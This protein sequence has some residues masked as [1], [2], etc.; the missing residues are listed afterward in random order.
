VLSGSL[1][2]QGEC[3]YDDGPFETSSFQKGTSCPGSMEKEAPETVEAVL[4][5]MVAGRSG[6]S[7][8]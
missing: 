4:V 5:K 7:I 3:N 2:A 8:V 1:A 6:D